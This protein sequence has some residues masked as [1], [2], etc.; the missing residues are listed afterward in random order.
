M[1]I[2]NFNLVESL[3]RFVEGDK[4]DDGEGFQ[5]FSLGK[6]ISLSNNNL[7]FLIHD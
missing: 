5:V 7:I 3:H 4:T 2:A 1:L 6:V